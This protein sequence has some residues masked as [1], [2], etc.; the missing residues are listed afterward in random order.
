MI[1][2]L[3]AAVDGSVYTE[4]VLRYSILL[5]RAFQAKLRVI[6]VLDVRIF[7]WSTYIGVEGF[8]PILPSS[9][10]L[11]ESRRILEQKASKVLHKCKKILTKEAL[12]ATLE[13][14]EGA[15]VEVICDQ[16]LRTDLVVLGARGEFAKWR[17]KLIG[18]T[19][20]AVSRQCHKPLLISPQ[21]YQPITRVLIPY[22]G[23][24]NSSRA[25]QLAGFVASHLGIP[26]T[27]LTVDNNLDQAQAVALR[28]REYLSAF[29]LTADV[30][31]LRGDPDEEIA[32]FAHEKKYDLVIMGAYGHSRIRE[33]ILGSTTEQVMRKI[34]TPLILVK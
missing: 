33:A 29:D 6:T 12:S 21:D 20:E 25:L 19:A 23:S 9:T 8:A 22:D 2:S 3:L 7:E 34:R 4:A 28:G 14:F 32:R 18:A 16:A 26:A 24:K 11:S 5:A 17:S 15:P 1:K 13:K 30:K 31:T 10:Y 27:V